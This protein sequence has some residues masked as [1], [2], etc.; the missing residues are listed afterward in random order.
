MSLRPAD[1]LSRGMLPTVVRRCVES[2][3]LVNEKALAHGG[4]LRQKKEK[5]KVYR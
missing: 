2:R 5:R 4:L 1:H 3:N